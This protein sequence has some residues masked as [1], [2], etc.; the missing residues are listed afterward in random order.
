MASVDGDR[1][2]EDDE[3]GE[4]NEDYEEAGCDV[5]GARLLPRA[6]PSSASAAASIRARFD[7]LLAA[8]GVL[9]LLGAI[10]A[11]LVRSTNAGGM[12]EDGS[13]QRRC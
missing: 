6:E 7:A 5:G 4:D 8:P 10:A 1:A 3:E 11:L 2:D 13:N 9:L 12:V